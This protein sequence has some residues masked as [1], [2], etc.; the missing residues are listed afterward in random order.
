MKLKTVTSRV[1]VD[2]SGWIDLH[3]LRT[4]GLILLLALSFNAARLW[5]W[6][7]TLQTGDA[8]QW[9]E[10][11]SHVGQGL[12]FVGCDTLKSYFP[13]CG[14]ANQVTAAREPAPVLL[15]ALVAGLTHQSTNAVGIV[16]LVLNL[17]ILLGVFCL[18]RDLAD[19]RVALV[20][21]L[22]L[23]FYLPA[24][25]IVP[26]IG[27]DLL[28]TLGV[29][30]GLFFF[31][32][33]R[34][35]ESARDW[36]AAGACIG[37]GVLSRS[38]I[39]IIAA[40][41]ALGL[42]VWPRSALHPGR[43]RADRLRAPVLFVAT[44]GVILLPWLV[45]NYKVF[46]RPVVGSTLVGYNL[47]RHNY[48]LPT[49][50]YLHFVGPDEGG[51]AIQALLA[52]RT[53]LRGTENEAQMGAVYQDEAVRIIAANPLRYALLSGYRFV[54][55]WFDWGVNAAY[56]QDVAAFDYIE[57]AQQLLLLIAGVV[58]LRNKWRFAWPLLVSIIAFTLGHMA[59][60]GRLREIIPVMPLTVSLAALGV[61]Q[62]G[63][64][65]AAG[66]SEARLLG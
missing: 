15:I 48:M 39:S 35:T 62:V 55:L 12:G 25:Q 64:R 59:L 10:I 63:Q 3:P 51:L 17:M 46:G 24:I 45:R 4:L 14:P 47:F 26:E 61:A 9:W 13:F 29:T 49:E 50:H 2:L 38:A 32:R 36:L 23:A 20:A 52:R 27:G 1:L 40:S 16:Q 57:M 18:T 22:I 41:L 19:T 43:F 5:T 7:P 8:A 44:V 21:A 60:M 42:I 6:P 31:V 28:G 65:L 54:V 30:W 33:G 11:A 37:L 66:K 56:G 34:R 58:G 53:D